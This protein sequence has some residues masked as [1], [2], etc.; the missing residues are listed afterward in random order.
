[1]HFLLVH[2]VF[3]TTD[4]AGGTRHYEFARYCVS[5]NHQFTV[6]G[7]DVNYL[8]AK[9]FSKERRFEIVDGIRVIRA[10]MP[11]FIH[12]S[13]T[14]RVVAFVMHMFSSF[15]HALWQ[16]KVDLVIGTSP[17]LFQAV[18]AYVISVIKWKPFLLEIRD[19]WP[20]FAVE[21]GV[22]K[23]PFLIYWARQVEVFLYRR[24][25]HILVNSPAYVD[26]VRSKGI[27]PEK[28]ALIPNGVDPNMFDPNER[29]ESIRAK[30]GLGSQFVVVYAGAIGPANDIQTIVRA[31]EKLREH[32]EICFVL[33][34]DG[35]SRP[36]IEE[37]IKKLGLSNVLL[38]GAFPKSEMGRVLGMA[39][40]CVATLQDI[41]MFRTTYPNKV[42]DYMA[43]GRPTLLAIDGVIREVVEASRGGLF[44]KPGDS[45]DLAEK[46]LQLFQNPELCKQMGSQ[47][48]AYVQTHFDRF[49][50]AVAFEQLC[51]AVAGKT[52]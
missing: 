11:A 22:L 23:S 13:Y 9:K 41:P 17:S 44:V 33:V 38:A 42:F 49:E 34:G 51:S 31:A 32:P 25:K 14:L 6:I 7:S 26:H 4:S 52:S 45:Q 8:D 3:L 15:W 21:M 43:A 30:L 12:K 16:R 50:H 1:M 20:D 27:A 47:A 5:K 24:A 28:I 37:M 40:V 29:G 18:T 35:K 2:H 10:R 46:T 19:L 36:Q 48:R 39:N